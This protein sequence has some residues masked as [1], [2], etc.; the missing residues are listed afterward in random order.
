MNR[1]FICGAFNFPRGGAASNYVQY[2]GMALREC[3]YEVHIVSIRNSEYSSPIYKGLIIDEVEYRLGK[4]GHYIDFKSGLNK[5][6][7]NCLKA[8]KTGKGDI[9]IVYSHNLWLHKSV[10]FFGKKNDVKVGAVVVEYFS[11]EQFSKEIDYVF[12]NKLMKKII[13]SHDFILPISTYIEKKLSG[14][15]AKQMVLPI[16]A[17][18]Y[19]YEYKE[20]VKDGIRRFIFPAKGKMKDALENMILAIHEV[21]YELEVNVEFHF[22]G[23]K[24]EEICKVLKISDEER[25]D[26][27]IIVHEWLEYKNLVELYQKMNFLLLARDINEMTKANFPSKVPEVMCYGVIP[28][29]SRVGDYTKYYLVDGENSILMDGCSIEEI[30]R[31]IMGS[32]LLD[33]VTMCKLSLQAYY[34]AQEK[35]YYKKWIN[36]IEDFLKVIK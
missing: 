35:F 36:K 25:L 34:T 4:L 18:P 15:H 5:A 6:I 2:F 20:K 17:D 19:E 33:N 12:Y 11:R 23:V 14:G 30:K 7:I 32:I 1:V 3:G 8:Q 26:P 16:M 27:R 29:A 22:C 28:I 10:Q 13:P 31:K 24:K 21:L 9:V